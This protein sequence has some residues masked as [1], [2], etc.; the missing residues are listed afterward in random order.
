MRRVDPDEVRRE[1]GIK[2]PFERSLRQSLTFVA[3]GVLASWLVL[4]GV[5]GEESARELFR[6]LGLIH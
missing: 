5:I 2:V 4:F 3:L 6:T 1:L